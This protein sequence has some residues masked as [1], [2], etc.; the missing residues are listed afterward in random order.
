MRALKSETLI[1]VMGGDSIFEMGHAEPY[2]SI[3][4]RL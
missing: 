4:A 2:I 1:D 3:P